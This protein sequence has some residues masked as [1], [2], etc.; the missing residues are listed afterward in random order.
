LL[1]LPLRLPSLPLL[2]P[3]YITTST[4]GKESE[5]KKK[6]TDG[7]VL[8]L[9]SFSFYLV[10]FSVRFSLFFDLVWCFEFVLVLGGVVGGGFPTFGYQFCLISF[11]SHFWSQ[12]RSENPLSTVVF[13]LLVTLLA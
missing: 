5:L 11:A 3:T 12:L 6:E 4:L 2:T 13:P 9:P 8:L 7:N 10:S 1:L